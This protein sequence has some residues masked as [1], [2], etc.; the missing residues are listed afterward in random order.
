MYTYTYIYM[1]L[2]TCMFKYI[3]LYI[4]VY[5]HIRI[6]ICIHIRIY[7][8]GEDVEGGVRNQ[9]AKRGVLSR[10]STEVNCPNMTHSPFFPSAPNDTSI[11]NSKYLLSP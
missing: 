9:Y 6:Y 1:Y 11:N 5:V 10:S 4:H 7:I 2:Y 8:P 3:R